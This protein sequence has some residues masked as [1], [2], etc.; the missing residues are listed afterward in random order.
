MTLRV[1]LVAFLLVGPTGCGIVRAQSAEE[2]FNKGN[3]YYRAG[4]FAEAVNEYQQIVG[5]GKVSAAVY[6]NLGN[7]YYRQGKIGQAIL[8]YERA[9]RLNPGDADIIHNLRLVNLKTLDRIESVPDLFIIQWLRAYDAFVPIQTAFPLLLAGWVL[10]FAAL[11]GV[12]VI[13]HAG[14]V[15]ILRWAVLAAAV[16]LFFSGATLGV[17]SVLSSENDEAIVTEPIATAKSSPDEQSVNAFVVHEGLKVRVSD[18]LGDWIK[19]TLAD[20]KVG[21]IFAQQCERI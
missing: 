1:L 8:G 12:Y 14:I 15:R 10:L 4:K 5:Q 9:L 21:W 18:R 11:A 17:H 19:I 3:D 13:R 7:A 16:L 2:L 20:G 6:F